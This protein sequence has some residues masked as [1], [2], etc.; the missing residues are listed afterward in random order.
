MFEMNSVKEFMSMLNISWLQVVDFGFTRNKPKFVE[1]IN[2][3]R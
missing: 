3:I 1:V 2:F